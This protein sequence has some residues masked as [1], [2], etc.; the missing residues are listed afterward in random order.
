MTLG[1]AVFG[2]NKKGG[3]EFLFEKIKQGEDF[4]QPKKGGR[5]L[6]FVKNKGGKDFSYQLFY[7]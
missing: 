7:R 1:K 5:R 6:C 4:F 3:Q 2:R